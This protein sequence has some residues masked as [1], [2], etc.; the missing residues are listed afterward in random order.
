MNTQPVNSPKTLLSVILAVVLAGIALSLAS[1]ATI[2]LNPSKDNTLYQF[3]AADGDRSNAVGTRLF[4][5]ET[6]EAEIRR[7]VLAFDIAGNIPAGSTITSVSLSMNMSRSFDSTARTV[8]L[9]KLL[10]DW[11][12]GTSDASGQEGMGALATTNDATWRHRFYNTIF[13]TTQGGDFSGT[14]SASQSVGAIGPYVWSSAQMVADVQSWLDNPSSN[15]GWLVKGDESTSSTAKRFDSRQSAS[16]PVLT[17]GY[18]AGGIPCADLRS[19]Q[20]RC[21]AT[22][23]G[24]KLQ[25][26][27][28][29]TNTSHDGED[30][31][32][33]VD[34]NSN[35][36]TVNGNKA[37][38]QINST[39]GTHTV[40]LTDPAGC[41]PPRMP[42][43]P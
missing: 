29:L 10:A 17:I 9:H 12:E 7:A 27:L 1:A 30:V 24:D 34:G 6:Q 28:V 2:N 40:E 15:F 32:I 33:T 36:V 38:L 14:V 8:E 22:A 31:T 16:P 39:P 26:K 19:F 11:G 23:R 20:V 13:W 42:T 21:V 3:G 5:G 41:F 4:T 37:T 35:Q 43:C 18:T 25:A